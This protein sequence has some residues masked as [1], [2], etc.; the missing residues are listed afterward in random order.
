M[1]LKNLTN[2]FE[3]S[4]TA[5]PVTQLHMPEE[6][7]CLPDVFGEGC[8]ASN[9]LVIRDASKLWCKMLFVMPSLVL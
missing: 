9:L 6:W 2:S 4:G 3:M 1:L 7:N 5:Y 8:D